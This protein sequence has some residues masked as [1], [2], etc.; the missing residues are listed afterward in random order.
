MHKFYDWLG[1]Y[2]EYDFDLPKVTDIVIETVCSKTGELLSSK[3]PGFKHEGSWSTVITIRVHGRRVFIE[4]NPSRI[5]RA[6]NLF[7]YTTIEQC[8][9]VYNRIL[10]QYGL[11]PL[12]KCTRIDFRQGQDGQHVGTTADGMV[13]T[14]IDVTSNHS[15]GKGNVPAYLKGISSQ[16]IGRNYGFLYPNGRTATWTT[17]ALGQGARLQF[18]KAYDKAFEMLSNSLPKAK[19]IF[20]ETSEEYKYIQKVQAYCEELGIVRFEQ[21]FKAEFLKRHHLAYWG[22]FDEGEFTRLH[23]DFLKLDQ[24][25]KVNAMDLLSIAEQL[26]ASGVRPNMRAANTTA[27]YAIQWM[28]AQT[29]LDF[30]KRQVNEHAA[31]LNRIGI[32]I[33]MPFDHT[34]FSP[35]IVKEI[36]EVTR[37]SVVEIPNWY[38]R[39]AGHLQLVAA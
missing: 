1:A 14:R 15:V 37:V 26:V 12:T 7:G 6:D 8:V 22:L 30:S 36:R 25:L 24:K 32:N 27:M 13:I 20:G 10:A 11:P 29:P 21:G 19:R 5:D 35:V 4:G 9:I 23:E 33:R 17:K 18:R 34:K 3:Q 38:K 28:N 16:A 39:P 2:Q 31:H